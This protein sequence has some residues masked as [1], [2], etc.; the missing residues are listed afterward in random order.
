MRRIFARYAQGVLEK[1]LMRISWT[2]HMRSAAA[3][4]ASSMVCSTHAS[5]PMRFSTVTRA[6]GRV[7]REF[8]ATVEALGWRTMRAKDVSISARRLTPRDHVLSPC[9]TGGKVTPG[10][11][12][13][14]MMDRRRLMC[15]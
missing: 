2:V 8:P 3:H 13:C 10:G 6:L 5:L 12:T 14:A 15:F 11:S 1:H 9:Q 7:R 4:T